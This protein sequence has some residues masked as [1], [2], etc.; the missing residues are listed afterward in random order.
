MADTRLNVLD[1]LVTIS[2]MVDMRALSSSAEAVF[3]TEGLSLSSP[4]PYPTPDTH[5]SVIDAD[6]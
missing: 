5:F 6:C 1:D 3:I 2:F 4:P